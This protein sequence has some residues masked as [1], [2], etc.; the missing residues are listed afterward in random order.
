M[1]KA[2]ALLLGGLMTALIAFVLPAPVDGAA[3]KIDVLA[4]ENFYGD[5]A[6][7]IGGERV[8]VTSILSNPDQDPHL[9]E[10]SPTIVR[11]ITAAKIVVYS[12]ANYDPWMD[13]LLKGT[14]RPGRLAIAAADLVNKKPGDNPHVW[15]DPQTMP[16]VAGALSAALGTVDPAHK[17]E[18]AARLKV[19]LGSL[20]PLNEKIAAIR[21]KFAGAPVAATEPVFGYMA[22]A[23]GLAMRDQRFQLAIM[24]DTEPSARDVAAF[25]TELTARSVRLLFYNKQAASKVV[26]HIVELARASHVPVVGVTETEPPGVSYQDWILR[27]LQATERAL[28]GPSS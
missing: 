28:A 11:Q 17:S 18:Y 8:A 15:Y 24:N 9:F 19:F 22:A 2:C 25:E 14:D 5:I 27:E 23:L 26:D 13:K 21:G 7:Q 12:G 20:D 4:A 3:G 6:Q 16:A 10:I 1:A